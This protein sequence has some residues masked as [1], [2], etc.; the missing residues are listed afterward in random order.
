MRWR[1]SFASS[2]TVILLPASGNPF[3]LANV[4]FVRPSSRARL[5]MKSA[6]KMRSLPAMPSASAM[7]ASLPLW[8]IAPCRRSSIEILL[9]ST[10][11][12][13]EPPAGAPP[14]GTSAGRDH[15]GGVDDGH[16]H[17]HPETRVDQGPGCLVA[18]VEVGIPAQSEIDRHEHQPRAMSDGDSKGPKP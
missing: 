4:D 15:R 13:V 10:A 11:N 3:E 12:I 9:L 14:R 1:A 2:R 17:G 8:M 6:A 5:V 16:Q 7:Q 18:G